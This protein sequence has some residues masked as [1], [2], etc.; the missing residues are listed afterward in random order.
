MPEPTTSWMV[1]LE[2]TTDDVEGTLSLDEEAIRFD[3]GDGRTRT[4]ALG[5]VTKVKRVI[6]SP[7]LVVHSTEGGAKRHTAFYFRKPP[8]LHPPE[9]E[10]DAPATLIG[11]FDRSKSPSRR[12]QRRVNANYLATAST[13]AGDEMRDWHVAMR[14]AVAAA[15]RRS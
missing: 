3:V 2:L 10:A 7:V 13:N 12:K 15:K 1:Q 5:D 4:I 9:P 14:A 6:G 11:P 8:P